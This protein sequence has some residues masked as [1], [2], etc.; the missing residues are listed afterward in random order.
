MSEFPE[1]QPFGPRPVQPNEDVKNEAKS[2]SPP[3]SVNYPSVS[4]PQSRTSIGLV[5]SALA[6]GFA[7]G[8]ATSRYQHLFFRQSKIDEF[9]DYAQAWI[10]EQGPK[11]ADPIKRSL[12]STGSSM[13]QAIKKVSTSVPLE[14][15]NFLQRPKPRK[16]LGIQI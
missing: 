13:E 8:Y 5:I 14:S 2:V 15:L 12:E 16:F 7:L 3:E 6:V 11:I 4:P 9:I 1:I 10:R